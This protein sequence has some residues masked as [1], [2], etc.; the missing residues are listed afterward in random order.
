MKLDVLTFLFSILVFFSGIFSVLM[1]DYQLYPL[2][3][4]ARSM[5]QAMRL[6]SNLRLQAKDMLIL[7]KK[8]SFAAPNALSTPQNSPQ[9]MKT[10]T[11]APMRP[12][13]SRAGLTSIVGEVEEVDLASGAVLVNRGQNHGLKSGSEIK[14]YRNRQLLANLKILEVGTDNSVAVTDLSNPHQIMAGDIFTAI[15]TDVTKI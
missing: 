9:R 6:S 14:I 10:I 15:S 8:T 3:D 1:V 11:L 12:P 5:D 4:A 13:D 2:S 7:H